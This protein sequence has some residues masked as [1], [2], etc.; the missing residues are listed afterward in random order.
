M[1][2]MKQLLVGDMSNWKDDAKL[3]DCRAQRGK[4]I[5]GLIHFGHQ[6]DYL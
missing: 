1:V 4:L 2:I 3:V 5:R 6:Y